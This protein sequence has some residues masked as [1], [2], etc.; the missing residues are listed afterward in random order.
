MLCVVVTLL[1]YSGVGAVS[2]EEGSEADPYA[3]YGV[4]THRGGFGHADGGRG[5][6]RPTHA[7]PT[8]R[9]CRGWIGAAGR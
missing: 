2:E 7:R 3:A 6:V 8:G 5:G 9:V 1:T 4:G